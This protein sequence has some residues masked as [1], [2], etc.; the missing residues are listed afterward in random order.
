MLVFDIE[1]DGFIEQMT[2]L[3]CLNI[4]VRG[5]GLRL[6][7]N[8][9]VYA[10]GTPARRDGTVE[11]G[12]KMLM[13]AECIGGHNIIGFDIPAIQKLYPWFEPKGK[14]RDSLV[15][16]RVIW[17]ALFDFDSRKLKKNAYP[18]EFQKT[19][20]TG[21]HKLSAW[22]FR[23][24]EYKGDYGPAKEAEAKALGLTDEDDIRLHVWGRFSPDMDDYCEQDV[25]VNV[26]LFDK[27]DSKGFSPEA[28]ELETIVAGIIR[29]QEK[30]GFLFDRQAAERLLHRLEV[31]HARLSDQLRQTFHPWWE[32]KRKGGKHDLIVPARD[33]RKQGYVK[34]CPATRVELVVFNPGS[35][36]HI[37]NRLKKLFGW[38]PVEFTDKGKAKVDETTLAGLDYP[39]AKLL[40]EYLTVEKR[41]GQLATGKQAWLSAVKKDGRIHGRVNSNGAVTGRMTHS[42]PNVAQV[43][44][45]GS[46]FG[47]E[48]RA[49]FIVAAGYLLVGCDAE[50][51]E[52]RMLGH[53]MARYD[54]GAYSNTVA[55]GRKEDGSDVHT[56]NQRLL[57]LN[58]RDNAKTWIYAYLYGA[59]TLKLGSIVYDDMSEARRSAF[60]ARYEPG[61]VREK[62]LSRLGMKTK[63]A[64]EEGLPALGQLQKL[65]KSKAKR[66]YIKS[67][68]GRELHVRSEHAA[69]NTL[70]QGGGAS[71]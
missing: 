18:P 11:D 62:A 36:D 60:N 8:G 47:E 15:E 65:V 20:L 2:V 41:L 16:A 26:A 5:T 33:N 63:R 34:G 1:T 28:L 29:L 50:G 31:Q 61:T 44:K 58:K 43:P 17:T 66:G 71:S 6:R 13:E 3:H 22:G 56:V 27:I 25:V 37:A 10:D 40:V 45:V 42:S 24:G 55:N 46:L 23:L 53:Y 30:H 4:V 7:F 39:E 12:L 67:L 35:R 70:L 32:P 52:L 19:G 64:I 51:L 38:T 69:L 54:G 9:G 68:D 57:G 14:V 21:T 59:G 49:L 48:C